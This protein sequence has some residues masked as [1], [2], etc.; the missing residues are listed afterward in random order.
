MSAELEA[1]VLD[2]VVT[3][4]K[5]R[6]GPTLPPGS[7]CANCGAVLRGAWCHDCGQ[8]AEDFHRSIWRLMMEAVEGITHLDGRFW[9]TTPALV[10]HPG[11]LTR[12]YIAGHRA[13]QIPPLRLFLVVLLLVFFIGSVTGGKADLF[14]MNGAEDPAARARAEAQIDK[15]DVQ[16][17]AQKSDAAARWIRPRLKAVLEDPE[18]FKLVLESQAERFAFLSLPVATLLLS[19][20][21][22][23]QRRFYIFDHSIFALHSL[24]FQGL[25]FC[26]ADLAGKLWDPLGSLLWLAAPVHLFVHMRGAYRTGVTGTLLRMTLLG[27]G[28]LIGF[29][30]LLLLLVLVG[31][32]AMG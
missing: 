13:S 10:L 2:G 20:L 3:T 24:S 29:V 11:K 17:G 22:V 25:L 15:L 26:V 5:P 27:I 1:V 21:F 18:R 7:P 6:H 31:L 30:V 28:S 9:V 19:L 8:L 4:R 23:F 14:K 12:D 32:S 16:I